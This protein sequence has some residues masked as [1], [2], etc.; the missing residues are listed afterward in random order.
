MSS[1]NILEQRITEA[2]DGKLS[3]L[4]VEQLQEKLRNYPELQEELSHQLRGIPVLLAYTDVQPDP[5][6]V[7]RLRNK[8]KTLPD[9]E[10]QFEIIFFFKR[11]VLAAGLTS[12][13]LVSVLHMIPQEELNSDSSEDEISMMLESIESEALDWAPN[14]LSQ[15][16]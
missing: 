1:Y 14:S 10:W 12:L 16:P 2:V 4:E 9:T 8:I 6:A 11:Y 7:S 13:L 3:P 15:E 5:F